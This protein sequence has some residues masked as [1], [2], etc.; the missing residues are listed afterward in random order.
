M[1][2]LYSHPENNIFN[3]KVNEFIEVF[4]EDEL[5]D[6]LFWDGT[7]YCNLNY[8][9]LK[10]KYLDETI[11]PRNLEQKMAFH[12]LQNP[13]I[14]VKLL[15]SAW[16]SGKTMIALN[17][18][19]D[20]ISRGTYS[21]LVFVRNNIIVAD[22]NDIGYM[23]GNLRDKM[24]IWS[25]VIADHLGGQDMLDRLIDDGIIETFPLSHMRGRSIRNSII[26][27]DECED[28]NDKLITLLLSRVEESSEIIFCGDIAQI[29]SK[30]F[31]KNKLKNKFKR[32][33]NMRNLMFSQ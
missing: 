30:K 32:R 10:N 31:E 21:K 7:K 28:M 19:L 17:Y 3:A 16:G 15:I 23:P 18:A 26:I 22:T 29:D 27:C 25:E 4:V 6:V 14:K 11:K 12:L 20:Q 33:K 9:P 5:K 1:A 8:K 24:S 13:N 2:E